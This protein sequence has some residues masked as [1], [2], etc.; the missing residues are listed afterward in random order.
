MKKYH[1]N[2]QPKQIRTRQYNG[3]KMIFARPT[4]HLTGKVQQRLCNLTKGSRN[5]LFMAEHRK[6]CSHGTSAETQ[7]IQ[8]YALLEF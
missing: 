3:P 5:V 7:N 2:S 8:N 4:G 6:T 1:F